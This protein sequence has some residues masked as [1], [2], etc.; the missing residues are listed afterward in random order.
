MKYMLFNIDEM[1]DI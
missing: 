1:F